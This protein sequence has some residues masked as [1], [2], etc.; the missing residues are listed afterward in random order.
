VAKV[1]ATPLI[2]KPPNDNFKN[3]KISSWMVRAGDPF[4]ENQILVEIE[5]NDGSK[6]SVL[7]APKSG[8]IKSIEVKPFQNIV[9]DQTICYFLDCD[10]DIH[11]AGMCTKCGKD[12]SQLETISISHGHPRLAVSEK[13]AKRI[14]EDNASRLRDTVKLSLVLDLD[15]T[16]V[17]ATTEYMVKQSLQ[18]NSNTPQPEDTSSKL[19]ELFKNE[20]DVFEFTLP[21]NPT[22]YFVKFRPNLMEFLK[23][24]HSLYELHI[25]TMGTKQYATK[26]ADLLNV[27]TALFK[28]DRIIS[29]DDCPDMSLKILSDF[30]LVTTQW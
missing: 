28:E 9:V 15:H 7:T 14:D 5:N 2:F 11:Y 17:H 8:Y 29:R 20:T 22:K 12:I 24:L 1:A 4:M 10:H 26:I 27:D 18:S 6:K 13:E 19:S 3:S 21:P 25:Y 30:F 16:L 23:L